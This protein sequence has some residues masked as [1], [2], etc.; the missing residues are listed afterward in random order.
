MK[1]LG[2]NKIGAVCPSR[3]IVDNL[4]KQVEVTFISKHV[5]HLCEVIRTKIP[6]DER[7]FSW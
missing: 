5:G 4:E 2:T 6:K 3:M 7:F 1:S